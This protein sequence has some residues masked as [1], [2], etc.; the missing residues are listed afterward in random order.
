MG[1]H[2]ASRI[3]YLRKFDAYCAEHAL[4]VFDQETVEGWV[5]AQLATSGRY[6]SWMSY[7]R[8]F[9]RWLRATGHADAYVLSDKWKAPFVPA[10]PYLLTRRRSRRSSPPRHGS[11]TSSPWRWQAVAFFTLMHSCGLRTGEARALLAGAGRP[12]RPAH[13]RDVVQRQPQ[14]QAADH[15]RR[16]RDPGRLRPTSTARFGRVAGN[17]LRLVDRQSGHR[18]RRSG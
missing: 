4:G 1:F 9:G 17:V 13:R 3:W 11:T 5:T 18:R 16:R 10:R 8:D 7:I 6:R 2:G 15:R 14:P 12:A